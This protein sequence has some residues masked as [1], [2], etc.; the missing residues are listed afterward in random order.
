MKTCWVVAG[1]LA[2]GL[3]SSGLVAAKG[4]GEIKSMKYKYVSIEI[5]GKKTPSSELEGMVLIVTGNKGVVKKGEKVLI[6]GTS[7]MDMNKDPA[8]ID[9]KITKG[10][11]AGKTL[12]G[13]MKMKDGTMTVCFGK[14]GGERPKEFSSTEGGG[15]VLE[16]LEE[17]K[18]P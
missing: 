11:N 7:K 4:K 6:E 3:A 13:I 18:E 2:L 12:K 15:H 1:V 14:P 8:T 17:L 16:V 5:D 9:V 10:E